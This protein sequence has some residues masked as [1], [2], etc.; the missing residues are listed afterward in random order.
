M[1][2]LTRRDFLSGCS[3]AIASLAGSRILG[4]SFAESAA[5]DGIMVVIFLRGGM[6]GLHFLGPAG[7]KDYLA[8]RPEAL[9]VNEKGDHA[10]LT[11]SG[12]PADLDF[13]LHKSAGPL[14]ELYDSRLLGFV[15]A[16]GLTNG[17]R[18]HFEAMDL[19][20]RGVSEFGGKAGTGWITRL[21]QGLDSKGP[22]PLFSATDRTPAAMLGSGQSLTFP[23]PE[24]MTLWGG[25][26]VEA[27]L[28]RLYTGSGEVHAA[29]KRTLN[30]LTSLTDKLKNPDGSWKEYTPGEGVK[31]PDGELGASLRTVARLIRADL[32]VR[33]A[34]VDL[35]GWD[36]H[37]YQ[38]GKFSALVDHLSKSVH[39]FMNDLSAYHSRLTVVVMSEFGRR[40]LANTSYGTD[41]GHGNVMMVMGGG[42]QG[43]KTY[44]AWPG[45][46]SHQLDQGAD[47]KITTD[48]RNVLHEIV[49]SRMGSEAAARLFQGFEPGAKTGI[50]SSS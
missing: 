26:P 6:D 21:M 17:T 11:I 9:R 39:S 2:D 40:L 38:E 22:I 16:C 49:G 28:R 20:E 41:H 3:A 4:L 31:Y 24:A 48:Y 33:V 14:K 13:R 32:G 37:E 36:T 35:G 44:G 7:D 29:G 19:M 30:A 23:N 43:G 45:L 8:A 34:A 1:I 18:S 46:A 25:G 50:V 15:H 47:L 10:G 5:T 42:V 27:H 12:G